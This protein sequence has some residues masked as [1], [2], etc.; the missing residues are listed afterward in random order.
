ME[1]QENQLAKIVNESGLESSKA[2]YILEMFKDYF[3]I[4][5]E[6]EMKASKIVAF[7]GCH[8]AIFV[9]ARTG[10]LFLREKRL[11]IEKTRKELKEQALREGKAIDGIANVLK[12][13]IVPIEEYLDKQE[14]FVEIKELERLDAERRAMEA[15][16]EEERIEKEKAD[17]VERERLRMENE[18]LRAEAKTREAELE[19][20]REVTRLKEAEGKR[21]VEA[22][23]RATQDAETARRNAERQAAMDRAEAEEMVK[24]ANLAVKV[25][26][27]VAVQVDTK[28]KNEIVCPHCGHAFTLDDTEY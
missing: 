22:A 2:Q 21:K 14:R 5:A 3:A 26:E 23:I 10:R 19:K 27:T 15:K 11:A 25:A 24:Q 6:W 8:K 20:E 9:V 13:L 12:G 4:A 16:A 17:L 28:L 7:E 1:N 18:R